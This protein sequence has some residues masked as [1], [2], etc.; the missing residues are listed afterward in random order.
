MPFPVLIQRIAD[1]LQPHRL[2]SAVEGSDRACMAAFS[3][4]LA[5]DFS[6]QYRYVD[7]SGET[8]VEQVGAPVETLLAG[9]QYFQVDMQVLA[10]GL[11][12][13]LTLQEAAVGAPE[14]KFSMAFTLKMINDQLNVTITQ[15][16]LD[17]VYRVDYTS[18]DVRQNDFTL[19]EAA[20]NDPLAQIGYNCIRKFHRSRV[21]AMCDDISLAMLLAVAPGERDRVLDMDL[22]ASGRFDAGDEDEDEGDDLADEEMGMIFMRNDASDIVA[23][24]SDAV[25]ALKHRDCAPGGGPDNPYRLLP[26]PL[27]PAVAPAVNPAPAAVA[28]V[29][30]GAGSPA[31]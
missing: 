15:A 4:C 23:N 13:E 30:P 3:H 6:T 26:G 10:D 5:P 19:A 27:A 20:L 29:R 25:F 17:S 9:S 11:Q 21:G 28:G 12:I 16:E 31:E 14:S 8:V 1:A 24:Y 7:L 18:G 22:L 2:F